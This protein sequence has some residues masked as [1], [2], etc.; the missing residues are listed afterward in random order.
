MAAVYEVAAFL[1]VL[2]AILIWHEWR[3]KHSPLRFVIAVGQGRWR[4]RPLLMRSIEDKEL[5]ESVAR[6]LEEGGFTPPKVLL[7]QGRP[8]MDLI[9]DP[10]K[11]GVTSAQLSDLLRGLPVRIESVRGET[12]P[13][14]YH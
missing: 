3:V 2:I 12:L 10:D 5:A 4:T 1:V 8:T 7:F 14:R 13:L 9:F 11:P 6:A